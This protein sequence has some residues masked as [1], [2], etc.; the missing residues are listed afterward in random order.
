MAV[1]GDDRAA[2]DLKPRFTHRG[3]T[4]PGSSVQ[5]HSTQQHSTQ[6][7]RLKG[8]ASSLG[9]ASASD[10]DDDLSGMTMGLTDFIGIFAL[11]GAATLGI[12]FSKVGHRYLK[13]QLHR[14]YSARTLAGRTSPKGEG[15][16]DG[17][18]RRNSAAT[19]IESRM[20][21]MIARRL[22][23]ANRRD[24]ESFDTQAGMLRHLIRRQ[25]ANIQDAVATRSIC[26][27]IEKEFK[28]LRAELGLR[29]QLGLHTQPI[30]P[31]S[32]SPLLSLPPEA[33]Q[34]KSNHN[35]ITRPGG[36]NNHTMQAGQQSSDNNVGHS[37]ADSKPATPSPVRLTA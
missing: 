19:L 12:I 37:I 9:G 8:A 1:A 32:P 36:Q 23:M 25:D 16:P 28:D 24:P 15:F 10:G 17:V 3:S 4:L 33:H 6:R 22:T 13:P 7:R 27:L 26:E 11:W 20:R 29:A 34:E 18:E 21:G 2:G 30:D 14:V 5:H 31:R 35:T